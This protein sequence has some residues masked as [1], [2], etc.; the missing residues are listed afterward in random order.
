MC[1]MKGNKLLIPKAEEMLD[2]IHE[3][4]LGIV[5]CKALARKNIFWPGINV[6]VEDKISRCVVFAK[7]S[8]K[9]ERTHNENGFTR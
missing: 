6:S 2:Y 5:K 4:H 7:P 9:S 1:L 3:W 8:S